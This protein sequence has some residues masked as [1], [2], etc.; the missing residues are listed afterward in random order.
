MIFYAIQERSVF[1]DKNATFELIIDGEN[2]PLN[3]ETENAKT[4]SISFNVYRSVPSWTS[5]FRRKTNR[6]LFRLST[7]IERLIFDT[8]IENHEKAN[9]I[10]GI[11]ESFFIL[12]LRLFG[13]RRRARLF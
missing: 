9:S 12:L 8:K 13:W 1:F 11:N 10:F 6:I 5:A 7:C 3:L 4:I 2:F